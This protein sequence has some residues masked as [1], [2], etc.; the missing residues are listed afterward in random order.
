MQVG[1]KHFF[2]W[3]IICAL[4][5][6]LAR[7]I[8]LTGIENKAGLPVIVCIWG[9]VGV[10]A[11]VLV[12]GPLVLASLTQRKFWLRF[13][14]AIVWCALVAI[15]IAQILIAYKA[16]GPGTIPYWIAGLGIGCFAATIAGNLLFLRLFGLKLFSVKPK[17]P[18]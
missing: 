18:A 14:A 4:P 3:T 5:F 13:A 11:G 7:T 12:G 2:G 9:A 6:A 15:A 16:G 8:D 10:I 1:I 17:K